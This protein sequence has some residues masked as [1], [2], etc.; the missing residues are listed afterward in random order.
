MNIHRLQHTSITMPPGGK[1][2]ARRFY[3]GI[4]GLTEIPAPPI[5]SEDRLIWFAVSDDGDELHLVVDDTFEP[6]RNR[7]HLCMVVHDLATIR[8]TLDDAGV[9]TE[10]ELPIAFRPRFSFRDPFNNKIELTEI[11]GNYLDAQN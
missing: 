9:Q 1:E 6:S 7:Q 11:R 3:A 4:L 8:K 10:D 5:M 2:E